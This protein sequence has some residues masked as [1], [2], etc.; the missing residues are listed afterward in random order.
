MDLTES[1]SVVAGVDSSENAR[2]AAEWAARQADQVGVGLHLVHAL[3]LPSAQSSSGEVSEPTRMRCEAGERLLDQ[4]ADG[5]RLQHPGLPI[6]TRLYDHAAAEILVELSND[7]RLVVTG[8]R[9]H[10][11]F[12][13]MLLGS[14]SLR[15][16]THS[17][18]PAVIVRGELPGEPRN[19]IVLGVEPG[20]DPEPI[21]FAFAMAEI[22]GAVVHAVRA[23]NLMPRHWDS[24][25]S[26][27]DLPGDFTALL[28]EARKEH[29]GVDV[30]ASLVRGNAVPSLI[31]HA[32]G[33]QLVVIGA[34]R[35]HAPLSTGA[36][37][38]VHG[39]LS[40]CPTPVAVVP[41]PQEAKTLVMAT[42]ADT[43]GAVPGWDPIGAPAR[44]R[45]DD[46]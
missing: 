18:G 38:V 28:A 10:G 25:R 41:S 2:H 44:L 29:P 40:H 43:A 37:Y 6:T 9:G 26:H 20:Q 13:G 36:G 7:A 8:T 3:D 31:E 39:L 22:T 32:R 17:H 45:S 19:E 14:V 33:A 12:S 1:Q 35:R 42:P 23:R 11:G 46:L 30:T 24:D 15:L 5:L 4:L 16:A 34:H 27:E 21:R